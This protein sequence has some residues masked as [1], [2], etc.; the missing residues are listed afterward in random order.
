MAGLL[1]RAR[2]ESEAGVTLVEVLVTMLVLSVVLVIGF[3][4][5]DRASLLTARTEAHSRVED[6]A[7]KALRLLTQHVRGA[8]PIGDPCTTTTDSLSPSFMPGYAN[9]MR[10]S[11]K[12]TTTGLDACARTEFV[13]GIVGTSSP[14]TLVQ[15]R[16]EYTGTV[17]NCPAPPAA[18]RLTILGNVVNDP[19][20]Q[21]LF[22]YY[23]ADGTAIA[24][25]NT[26]AVKKASSV[27]V[28]LAV[29]YRKNADP[30]V[31]SSTAA[32]RNN[33]DR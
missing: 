1:R 33:V 32:L 21:P 27:K 18:Q 9:C 29:R 4:F 28:T 16:A 11:V 19:S 25:S 17:T 10:F 2:T 15:R 5:L 26:A 30:I 31:L 23:A 13:Y 22:T 7:Q 6:E 8:H 14:R 24:T 20:S 12:R 3:D